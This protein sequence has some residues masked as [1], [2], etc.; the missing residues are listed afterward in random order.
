MGPSALSK[1]FS[2]GY[3]I[4]QPL[5][6]PRIPHMDRYLDRAIYSVGGCVGISEMAKL[7]GFDRT[8]GFPTAPYVAI[9]RVLSPLMRKTEGL[10]LCGQT[11]LVS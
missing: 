1:I 9:L 10:M 8:Y 5:N 3:L 4:H 6:F 11:T 7:F 2:L